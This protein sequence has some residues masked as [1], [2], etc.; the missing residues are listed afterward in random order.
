MGDAAHNTTPYGGMGDNTGIK[1]A[2]DLGSL[3][4]RQKWDDQDAA[5]ALL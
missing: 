3:L 1:D 4:C 2:A 5:E